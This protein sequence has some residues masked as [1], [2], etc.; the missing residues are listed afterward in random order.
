MEDPSFLADLPLRRDERKERHEDEMGIAL[1]TA[2]KRGRMQG[3]QAQIR[4]V[5]G[6]TV[7][8]RAK[9]KIPLEKIPGAAMETAR[10][11][12]IA[13]ALKKHVSGG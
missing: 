13:T 5:A 10:A 4:M 1:A 11:M 8:H 6:S 3:R 7:D 12:D 2:M 9:R